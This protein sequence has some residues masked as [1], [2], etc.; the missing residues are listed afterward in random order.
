M[1]DGS[2]ISQ[3]YMELFFELFESLPRQGPGSLECAKRALSLCRG[4][5]DKPAILDL[6]CGCGAQTLQLAGLTGGTIVA[7]D[8]HAPCIERLEAEIRERGLAGRVKPLAGDMTKLDLAPASFDL[9]WSEGAFYNI[10]I[11]GALAL[12]RGLL[13][14]GGYLAFTDA[15]WLKDDPP[16]EV[17]AAFADYSGM[18][19]AADVIALVDG[20]GFELVGHFTLPEAAWWDDFYA[21]MERRIGEMRGKYADDA[22]ALGVID[23]LAEEPE[24][25]RRHSDFYGYEF[26]VARRA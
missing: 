25:Y 10:G 24:M 14:P 11:E 19:S 16:P 26:F 5:P 18:G 22:Q 15:V 21:P 2:G 1:S 17:K 3:R 12:C 20:G 6:G 23:K 9:A 4:L 8:S 7:V 13:K